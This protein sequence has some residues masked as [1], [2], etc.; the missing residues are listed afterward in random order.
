MEL[1]EKRL[2]NAAVEFPE[3]K[4]PILRFYPNLSCGPLA[5]TEEQHYEEVLEQIKRTNDMAN[6]LKSA[7]ARLSVSKY[8]IDH[9]KKKNARKS[10]DGNMGQ[11]ELDQMPWGG[12]IDA[13]EDLMEMS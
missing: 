2:L 8:W 5:K 6:Q 4:E 3:D 13:D 7:D 9:L 11:E 10:E 1:I 12:D